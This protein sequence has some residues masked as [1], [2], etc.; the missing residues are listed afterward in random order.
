MAF[1]LDTNISQLGQINKAGDV[2][3]LFQELFSGEVLTT[4]HAD[5]IALG[6]TRTRTIK[7]GK[8][9]SFPL[10]GQNTASYH[11]PGKLIQGNKIGHAKRIVTIDDVAI[12]PVFIDDL[13]E[14][15]NHYDVRSHYSM[16][17]GEALSGL[18]DRN[19]FRQVAKAASITDVAS[20]QVAGLTV[21]PEETYT[22]NIS[23]AAVGDEDD[24]SKLVSAIF[25]ART[26]LRNAKVKEKA[27]VVMAPEQYE[28]LVNV[29]DTNK[30]TWMN[31]DVGGTG[32][33]SEGTIP[34]VAGMSIYETLNL[35]N[36][37]ESLNTS[38]PEPIADTTVGSGNAS[39]YRGDYSKVVALI[40]TPSAV[41]TTK[42]MDLT[43][44]HV[45]E[46]LR[47]GH[48]MIAKLA[49]GHDILR[50]CC[51]VAIYKA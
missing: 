21:L 46:P 37:D 47:L 49:V 1:P 13:D 42:L 11:T 51:A 41:A 43:T 40:F 27:V 19:I 15:M 29:Q 20:A 30:V 45:P 4:F 38:D 9:A 28:A 8:S 3:A 50:P 31:S 23:L 35:P 6:L 39:K 17:C 24:G 36:A 7:S 12:S 48:T 22:A 44:V 18:V 25:K 5:N 26:Q 34:R 14:A 16:E 33:M 32:S 2:R 10:M